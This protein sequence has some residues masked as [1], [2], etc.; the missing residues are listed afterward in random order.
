MEMYI[1][2]FNDLPNKHRNESPVFK[3]RH[4]ISM[5]SL[6]SLA[7]GYF[8]GVKVMVKIVIYTAAAFIK[9]LRFI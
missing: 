2:S 9:I 3:P 1:K 6:P 5:R 7:L 4:I 8:V